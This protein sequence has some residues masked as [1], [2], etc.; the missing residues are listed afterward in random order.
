MRDKFAIITFNDE[1]GDTHKKRPKFFKNLYI[2]RNPFLIEETEICQTRGYN[3]KLGLTYEEFLQDE[4][5]GL[6][7]FSKTVDFLLDLGVT[8]AIAP[9][10]PALSFPHKITCTTGKLAF[11]FFMLEAVDKTLHLTGKSRKDV[12]ILINDSNIAR[13]ITLIDVLYPHFNNLS[14]LS[15]D[16]KNPMLIE[17][18]EQVFDDCGLVLFISENSRNIIESAD[19][20]INTGETSK[21]YDFFYKKDAVYIDLAKSSKKTTE[22]SSKREDIHIFNYYYVNCS[23]KP[24]SA[25]LFEAILYINSR[26]FRNFASGSLRSLATE[27]VLSDIKKLKASL[28]ILNKRL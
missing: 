8:A 26:S 4:Q 18:A 20:I 13:T 6:T 24:I 3:I 10:R 12:N 2:K 5:L 14:I 17:K 16:F 11:A 22:L 21:S 19:I 7:V 1:N 28:N 25:D 27:P 15:Q 23:Q 9:K